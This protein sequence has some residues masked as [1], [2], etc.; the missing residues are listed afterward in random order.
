MEKYT[1]VEKEELI[2][3][4]NDVLEHYN[5]HANSGRTNLL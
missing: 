2:K 5:I 4:T 1:F 3:L